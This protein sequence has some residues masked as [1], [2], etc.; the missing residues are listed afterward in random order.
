MCDKNKHLFFQPELYWHCE[1]FCISERMLPLGKLSVFHLLPLCHQSPH[2]QLCN[3]DI[4]FPSFSHPL[5]SPGHRWDQPVLLV[6]V[7]W[8]RWVRG[9]CG[10]FQTA[11]APYPGAA[12]GDRGHPEEHSCSPTHLPG[13]GA[14]QPIH[15]QQD[16][17]TGSLPAWWCGSP[18]LAQHASNALLHWEEDPTWVP[19]YWGHR[20]CIQGNGTYVSR[21]QSP[22]CLHWVTWPGDYEDLDFFS[23]FFFSPFIALT[24]SE[25]E[26]NCLRASTAYQVDPCEAGAAS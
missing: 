24:P 15:Q 1:Y 7:W 10:R 8:T 9:S 6:P 16:T 18:G 2:S 4:S 14:W 3:S 23:F 25:C 13:R 19:G 21:L 17:D 26:R 5:A 22:C 11:A 20:K 12:A